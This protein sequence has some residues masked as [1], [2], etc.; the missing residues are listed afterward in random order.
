MSERLDDLEPYRKG[1]RRREQDR[2]IEGAKRR[3]RAWRVAARAARLLKESFGVRQVWAFGSL[4][5][6]QLD[7]RSD[8]DLAVA[9][10][11]ERDLCRAVGRLQSLDPDFPIDVVRL[12]DAPP[13]LR[14]RIEQE[15]VPL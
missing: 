3:E 12:E 14:R 15:G 2:R 6:N 4:V 9:G 11:A 1:W 5:R 10:L 7:E 8:I 13:S